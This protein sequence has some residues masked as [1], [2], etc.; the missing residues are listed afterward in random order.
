MRIYYIKVYIWRAVNCIYHISVSNNICIKNPVKFNEI[1]ICK[2]KDHWYNDLVLATFVELDLFLYRNSPNKDRRRRFFQP[3][4]SRAL[5]SSLPST[6]SRG[7]RSL[8]QSKKFVSSIEP[9]F[10]CGFK[11]N[12]KTVIQTN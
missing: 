9:I 7:S 12:T 3:L 8:L 6:F 11:A 5:L 10:S 4:P 2:K 1:Y